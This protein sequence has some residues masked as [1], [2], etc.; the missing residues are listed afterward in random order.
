MVCIWHKNCS[1]GFSAAW[2]VNKAWQHAIIGGEMPPKFVGGVYGVDPP[3]CKDQDVVMVD[4]TYTGEPL[5]R[6]LRDA[7]SVLVLDHHKSAVERLEG[8]KHPKLTTVFDMNRS[9][10]RIAWDYY[11]PGQEAPIVLQHVEDRDLWRFALEGTKE[12]TSAVFS[13]DYTFE[14]WNW[15]MDAVKPIDRFDDHT[16]RYAQLLNDGKA[17]QRKITK[18]VNEL[19]KVNQRTMK[20]GDKVVPC[21]NIPYILSSE[22][23][24]IMGKNVDFAACYWDTAKNRT[25]SLRSRQDGG[26]DVS[27]VAMKYGGGGHKNASGFQM[28][29]GW[30]GDE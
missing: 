29:L 18:D 27:A 19:L 16:S 23:G 2:V 28:P 4:F 12:I 6:L 9:G 7:R 14:N 22:A 25:F 17:I 8:F 21:A 24:E 15:M 30:N 13:Y 5:E 20:I 10:A 26:D 11:F 1:D 3:K